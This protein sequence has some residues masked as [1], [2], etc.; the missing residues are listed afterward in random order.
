MTCLRCTTNALDKVPL[1]AASQPL[2]VTL[3]AGCSSN[4]ARG[5]VHE[6]TMYRLI[7]VGGLERLCTIT[8]YRS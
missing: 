8:E 6:Q 3:G 2:A 1:A 7:G 5:T 4:D